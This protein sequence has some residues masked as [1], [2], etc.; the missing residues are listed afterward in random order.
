MQESDFSEVLASVRRFVR[1]RVV[2]AEAE[3]ERT[4]AIP[5]GIRTEAADMG[6]F[7]FAIPELYGGLGLSMSEEVRL[8]FELGYTT[9][10]FRSMFGTNN[11]I[12]GHVL[13][14]GATEEQKKTYLPRIASGEWVASFALTE[15]NAGS[16][17]AGLVTS[18]RRDGD[19]WVI[20][21][22]KRFITNAPHADVLMVFART[23]PDATGGRGI[24]TFMVERGTPGVRVGP[25]DAKMGQAGAWTADVYLD[26][27]RVGGH[28]LIGGPDG[29]GRGY[30]TAMRCLAH[31]RIHI[32]ALCVGLSQRLL[33]ES[34]GYAATREQGGQVIGAHQLIQ[35]LLA[36]SATDLYASRALVKDVAAA[37][38]DGTD[39]R[40]GP[41][42]AKYFASEA[43][44]RIADRAVQI[45]GGSGYMRGVPVERFY[46]DARLFRIYEGTSQ[47][48]QIVIARQLLAGAG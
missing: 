42:C 48:Q 15:E 38:D 46:R 18:A 17:P 2:P 14:E 5:A 1:E 21:G 6:L 26:E 10:A 32:A 36:D 12:A 13:L 25:K 9:P 8:V 30:A 7:G 3:I 23:D 47:I 4:D 43:V 37:F 27:V 28:T 40:T 20:N 45:H 22:A 33:D 31:G 35:G 34:V 24:S 44:G 19:D 29:V 16:D 41:S 39:T 11:G